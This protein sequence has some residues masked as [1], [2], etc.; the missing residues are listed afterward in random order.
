MNLRI[1]VAACVPFSIAPETLCS[2]SFFVY[3]LNLLHA[4]FDSWTPGHPVSC[5]PIDKKHA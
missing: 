5:T 3:T 2:V 4:S 1:C